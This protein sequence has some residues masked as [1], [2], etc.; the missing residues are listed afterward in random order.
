MISGTRVQ[1]PGRH[2]HGRVRISN[3]LGDIGAKDHII[4][5]RLPPLTPPPYNIP[6]RVAPGRPEWDRGGRYVASIVAC[7]KGVHGKHVIS[8]RLFASAQKDA[9]IEASS[10]TSQA[11]EKTERRRRSK[12]EP[13]YGDAA[14]AIFAEFNCAAN[15]STEYGGVRR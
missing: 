3:E 14:A 10:L 15:S 4:M 1:T 5:H 9:R 11:E 8:E 12:D 6:G 13:S 7:H 2:L